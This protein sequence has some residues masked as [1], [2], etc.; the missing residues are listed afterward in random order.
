MSEV[1]ETAC[2]YCLIEEN[3]EENKL[4]E[5]NHCGK[6][7]IHENCLSTWN[8][9]YFNECLICRKKI[10]ESESDESSNGE[11][12]EVINNREIVVVSL[13]DRLVRIENIRT[14][15][16]KIYECLLFFFLLF[17]FIIIFVLFSTNR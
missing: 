17:L 15:R 4:I 7:L 5:Y 3:S 11:Y 8:T 2:I 14:R 10:I 1:S 16:K 12:N 6:Y 13:N 9:Q